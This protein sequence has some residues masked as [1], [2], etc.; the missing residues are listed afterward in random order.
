LADTKAP[1]D[2]YLTVRGD[3]GVAVDLDAVPFEALEILVRISDQR[4][5]GRVLAH[6]F[7][8]RRGIQAASSYRG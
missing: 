7:C 5:L 4:P 1:P 3:E 8:G 6:F 2:R